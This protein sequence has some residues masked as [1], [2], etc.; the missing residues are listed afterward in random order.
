MLLADPRRVPSRGYPRERE[1][2]PGVT[3]IQAFVDAIDLNACPNDAVI[4]GIN[5]YVGRPWGPYRARVC[6]SQRQL[7]PVFPSVLRAECIRF[8]SSKNNVGVYRVHR[9]RPDFGA[10]HRRV[11]HFPD[12]PV[13]VAAIDTMIGAGQDAVW[14]IRVY[15]QGPH[16]ALRRQRGPD[17]VPGFSSVR[18]LR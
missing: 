8:C 17:P 2:Y 5:N 11:Q 15:G 18:A 12:G 13:V 4:P 1:T 9:D 14:T 16:I 6:Y 3:A 7:L 10:I